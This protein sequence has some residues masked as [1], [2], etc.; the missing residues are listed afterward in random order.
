MF[1]FIFPLN[2]HI[3]VALSRGPLSEEGS[4]PCFVLMSHYCTT[5][6]TS[7]HKEW[8]QIVSVSWLF[9]LYIQL[10]RP[11]SG[12]QNRHH[13]VQPTMDGGVEG[14][15][16][17]KWEIKYHFWK[18]KGFFRYITNSWGIDRDVMDICNWRRPVAIKHMAYIDLLGKIKQ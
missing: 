3:L 15:C 17:T 7:V 16:L 6:M 4:P 11:V 12:F 10:N 13:L 8:L 18:M 9:L 1:I 2:W 5:C 14:N